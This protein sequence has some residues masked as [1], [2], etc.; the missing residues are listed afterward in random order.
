MKFLISLALLVAATIAT[1]IARAPNE[2]TLKTS[3]TSH[4]EHNDLYVYAYHTGAAL[5]D[6]VLSKNASIATSFF[7]N[8]T[9]AQ[10]DLQTDFPW[11]IYIPG[12]TNYAEWEQVQINVGNGVSGFSV[13]DGSLQGSDEQGFGGWLVCD[14]YHNA[15]QLFFLRPSHK[16]TLPSS[17]STVELKTSSK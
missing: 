12:D 9:R 15:P 3:D 2:F 17:C 5:N 1:P 6:A 16:P 8:G 4:S 7:L 13:K 10:A 11:G 14:W